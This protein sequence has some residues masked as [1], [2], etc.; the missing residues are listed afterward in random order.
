M[1]RRI[2]SNASSELEAL[3]A[4]GL[5]QAYLDKFEADIN[6]FAT[7][8]DRVKS[9]LNERQLSNRKALRISGGNI[10]IAQ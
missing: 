10:F 5:S 3:A 4:E 8:A 2:H 7:A 6:A 1:A 9:A